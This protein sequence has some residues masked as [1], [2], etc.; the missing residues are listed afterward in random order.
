MKYVVLGFQ[1][2]HSDV[3]SLTWKNFIETF[4]DISISQLVIKLRDQNVKSF[5]KLLP[6]Q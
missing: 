2:V 3:F 1:F 4:H 5:N 6:S